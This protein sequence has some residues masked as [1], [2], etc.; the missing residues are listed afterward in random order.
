MLHSLN[1]NPIKLSNNLKSFK[2]KR[3]KKKNPFKLSNSPMKNH[4][5]VTQTW[6]TRKETST[7]SMIQILYSV[8]WW[9]K[10]Q[11]TTRSRNLIPK[12]KTRSIIAIKV[13]IPRGTPTDKSHLNFA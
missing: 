5:S 3:S 1:K 11:V 13:P 2:L 12:N 8:Q 9:M 4:S 6:R 7:E 10:S